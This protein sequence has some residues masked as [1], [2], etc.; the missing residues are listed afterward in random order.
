VNIL[1][2]GAGRVGSAMVEDLLR[3]QQFS[4]AV[5]D[6]DPETLNQFTCPTIEL[7]LS[8]KNKLSTLVEKYDLVLNAVP[9]FMGF[10]VFKTVIE[11]GTNIV[12]I[13]FFP[14]DPFSLN[15]IAR[16]KKV[17]AVMD[18]GVAPGLSNLLVG[19]TSRKLEKITGIYIYV[20]GLPLFRD[21]PYEY[22]AVFSPV[23]VIEE[24][25]RPARYRVN[26]EL[27]VKDALTDR[28]LITF[29]RV[30]T[31]EAFNTDGL[32]TLLHTIDCPDMIEKTLRYP[33]H[34]DKMLLLRES[35]FFNTD[36]IDVKGTKVR[37]LDLTVQ[38]LFPMWEL[39]K[40]EEDITVMRIVIEGK[41]GSKTFKYEYNLFDRYDSSTHT[42]S[43]A[44]TTG[45]SATMA[46]RLIAAGLYREVG[47]S[48]PE[49]IGQS[50]DCVQFILNGLQYR[51]IVID[52]KIEES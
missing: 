20:G 31:L 36:W 5:A 51:G 39:K 48:P 49:Q 6:I 14:E 47:I 34:I 10:Q 52:Q 4:I 3:D 12:D 13:A 15:P 2:L 17:I 46:I 43:M 40:G 23:D 37:P 25:T 35:G 26:G 33:G 8:D 27:I 30:G 24:Y 18:C 42:T 22:R 28:E 11:S 38:L 16:K 9:G 45:Y 29:P 1:V 7:D 41:K 44:R 50:E 19:Y 21:W 32:R